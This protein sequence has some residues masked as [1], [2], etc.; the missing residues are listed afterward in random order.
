MGVIENQSRSATARAT[1][2]GVLERFS[3]EQFMDLISRD[4]AMAR[5][6]IL[7]LSVRLRRVDE[8]FVSELATSA[9]SFGGPHSRT[10]QDAKPRDERTI[11]LMANSEPLLARIGASAIP[12]EKLP[13]VVGRVHLN[14][15]GAS[16]TAP[17]LLIEDNPPFRLSRQ[18][19]MIAR[20]GEKSVVSDLGSTLGT[21]VNGQPIGHHFMR[22]TA[23]LIPG[24]NEVVAG[25]RGS[26]FQFVVS[27]D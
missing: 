25:G 20:S 13:F 1:T 19:F 22:D 24:N 12:V 14:S 27:V 9:G 3:A 2:N 18:H 21:I 16:P 26:L 11:M 6:V 15:E 7:R 5:D 23:P 4:P 10:L 17:D 8:K